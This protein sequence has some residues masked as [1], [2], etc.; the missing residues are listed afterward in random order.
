MTDLELMREIVSS[1][2]WHIA[3]HETE[4]VASHAHLAVVR[5]LL[6]QTDAPVQDAQADAI[7]KEQE[8]GA[9]TSSWDVVAYI[10]GRARWNIRHHEK[11]L[12]K[13]NR[14]LAGAKA[15]LARTGFSLPLTEIEQEQRQK[16]EES[17]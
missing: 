6:T 7:Y 3:Y 9:Q 17:H 15:L 1:A 8:E 2:F 11:E 4:L 5:S 14:K 13:A 10:L 12:Q 16:V